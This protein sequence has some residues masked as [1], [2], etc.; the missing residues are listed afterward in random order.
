MLLSVIANMVGII[1][2]REWLCSG[3]R[4]RNRATA[5]IIGLDPCYRLALSRHGA[6][7]DLECCANLVSL[8]RLQLFSM[9][10]DPSTTSLHGIYMALLGKHTYLGRAAVQRSS[11]RYGTGLS[12]RWREHL[13]S[14]MKHRGGNVPEKQRRSRYQ[15]MVK[16]LEYVV[17]RSLS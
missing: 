12:W 4:L 13:W 5:R 16:E 9:F 17:S 11:S 14:L 1:E 6:A 15:T 2:T 10:A 3:R 8:F 7:M